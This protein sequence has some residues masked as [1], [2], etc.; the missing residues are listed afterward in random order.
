MT[1]ACSYRC[2]H[3]YQ[4]LDSGPDISDEA[5]L[6]IARRVRDAG[7]SMFDIE[8]G[9][10]LLRFERLLKL[11]RSLG[12]GVETWV[13]TTGGGLRPGMLES[14][15]EAGM[16]GIMVSLHSPDAN[17]HDALTGV[18]GSFAVAC[19]AIRQCRALGMAAAAN[20]VLSEEELR[21]GHLANL[22]D[23]ARQLDCD[24]VQLIHPKA[25][26]LWLGRREQMQNDPELVTK[27]RRQHLF[28]NSHSQHDYPSLAAQV[29][30]EAPGVLGCTAGAIDRFYV[31]AHGE[32]QPC[33]FLNIS[34]G[35][36]TREPFEEILARMRA[37]FPE[38]CTDWLCCA[39]ASAI[40]EH[41]AKLATRQTPLPWPLTRELVVS[42]NRGT[43][44]PVYR[45]LGIY[46]P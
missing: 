9:E 17:V 44:T 18:A 13:N 23:L 31:N 29:F 19:N 25:A 3:C 43:P 1:K 35:N 8:G 39:Q 10:P 15:R 2:E 46:R 26:G 11:V 41:I 16:F 20:S 30:E 21:A 6:E 12:P 22:M 7:T 32:V 42:W 14:L 36:A 28:Y 4:K 45:A 33:E 34:F 24:F 40:A 5:L 38:P 37:A 27:V